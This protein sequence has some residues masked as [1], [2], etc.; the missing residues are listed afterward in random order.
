MT[1][2]APL[3]L[4]VLAADPGLT[5]T[6]DD[7]RAHYLLSCFHERHVPLTPTLARALAGIE[8]AR[9]PSAHLPW[10]GVFAPMGKVLGMAGR[11]GHSPAVMADPGLFHTQ[12]AE[13]LLRRAGSVIGSVVLLGPANWSPLPAGAPDYASYCR[14]IETA[15]AQLILDPAEM[16]EGFWAGAGLTLLSAA[17]GKAR[18]R[19]RPGCDAPPDPRI[20]KLIFALDPAFA[21]ATQRDF[22]DPHP[23]SRSERDR[24]GTR[25][26][27]GGVKGVIQTTRFEDFGDAALSEFMQPRAVQ[28]NKLMHEGYLMRHRPPKRTPRRDLLVMVVRPQSGLTAGDND[29]LYA[30]AWADSALRSQIL[31]DAMAMRHSD[32]VFA[33]LFGGQARL[34]HHDV[35]TAPP[36][37]A[38]H[39]LALAGVPRR[40]ALTRSG[41]AKPLMAR[42][43][44]DLPRKNADPDTPL[45]ELRAALDLLRRGRTDLDPDLYARRLVI[46]C[47][48]DT[49]PEAAREVAQ[50]RS[51]W[52]AS[53]GYAA[54]GAI[55]LARI[56]L[57]ARLTAGAMA[58]WSHGP[59]GDVQDKLTI[60]EDD[61]SALAQ[62]FGAVS[63]WMLQTIREALDATA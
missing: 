18:T 59:R 60:P 38:I 45:P 41:L 16:G 53:L 48:T 55:R 49:D 21:V 50:A 39:P 17:R 31:L 30:A 35:E 2:A 34:A 54:P 9:R 28:M 32:L 8:T 29:A 19:T 10:G 25:P 15:L 57:P 51:V 12:V 26:K 56:M 6:P 3:L 42:T 62:V 47:L 22:R 7:R 37:P 43:G 13:P 46:E 5:D 61:D 4:A 52:A 44:A 24:A 14:R 11:F 63:L 33:G 40:L 36:L 1:D 27:E 20:A 23:K 58:S